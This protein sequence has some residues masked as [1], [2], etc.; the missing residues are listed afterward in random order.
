M[1]DIL[2][3]DDLRAEIPALGRDFKVMGKRA[4]DRMDITLAVAFIDRWVGDVADYFAVKAR[5]VQ[6]V[7]ERLG[8]VCMLQINTL[9]DPCA[10]DESSLYLT[11]TGLS[12]E[13]G[14]DGEVGRGNRV[15]GL[16][17]P[18]R[19][20]SLEAAAGKNPAAHVGK[21]YNVLA[22]L[23]AQRILNET[24]GV[25]DV[26]VR[27]LSA[28]GSPINQPQLAAVD[29]RAPGGLSPEQ[30]RGIQERVAQGLDELPM[31][32]RQLVNGDIPVC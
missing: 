17:T 32:T 16:I 12:A 28:I 24:D 31:L 15:N 18:Y 8:Q 2:N 26:T 6:R 9:D 3:S 10:R 23:L 11:V 20:M 22:H 4:G 29:V 13:Q 1:A 5:L 30:R 25:T 14:D 19:P 27:L 21:L 7:Q